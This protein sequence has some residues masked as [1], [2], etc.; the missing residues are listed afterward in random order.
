MQRF[1]NLVKEGTCRIIAKFGVMSNNGQRRTT[2][3]T[4]KIN[5]FYKTF[6]K[7]CEDEQLPLYGLN[8]ASFDKIIKNEIDATFLIGK[9]FLIKLILKKCF[10]LRIIYN[11]IFII[12]FPI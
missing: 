8:L 7:E 6:I 1:K 9:F 11:K 12:L 2:N 10:I 3:N 5:F 4:Y